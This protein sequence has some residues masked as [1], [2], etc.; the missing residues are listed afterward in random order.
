MDFPRIRITRRT[1]EVK[2]QALLVVF[3]VLP[4]Q[5]HW[6][7]CTG[8]GRIAIYLV[9]KLF[10][11]LYKSVRK[12]TMDTVYTSVAGFVYS[13]YILGIPYTSVSFPY[14]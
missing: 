10:F 4:G 11:N 13:I 5:S 6:R 12:A 7:H 3:L 1:L 8:E 9:L 2:V 14:F